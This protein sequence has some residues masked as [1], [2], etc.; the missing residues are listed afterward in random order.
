ME[1]QTIR[2]CVG[3]AKVGKSLSLCHIQNPEIAAAIEA[4]VNKLFEIK[5]LGSNQRR[6]Q[7]PWLKR[8]T[9]WQII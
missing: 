3:G 1:K 4:V 6:I 8:R 7:K 2:T 9:S 5:A